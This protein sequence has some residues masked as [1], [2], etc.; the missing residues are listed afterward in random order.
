MNGLNSLKNMILLVACLWV[1]NSV[2]IPVG[3]PLEFDS[4]DKATLYQDVIKELRCTVCQNQSLV[5][6]NAG[7]ARDLRRNTYEMVQNDMQRDE[8]IQFM[9]DRY[10]D[11]VLYSPPLRWYTFLLWFGPFM[12]LAV[13]V[14][15]LVAVIRGRLKLAQAVTDELTPDERKRLQRVL[16][17]RS[18]SAAGDE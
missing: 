10:G 17:K 14:G 8:I 11:F 1:G 2:A 18:G 16:Q 3:A 5:D 12:L 7:L 9:V 15:A 13:G 4:P 6:S